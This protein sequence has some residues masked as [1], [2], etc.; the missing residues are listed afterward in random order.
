[1]SKTTVLTKTDL[2]KLEAMLTEACNDEDILENEACR[3]DSLLTSGKCWRALY[4]WPPITGRLLGLL[5]TVTQNPSLVNEI[6][7]NPVYK[8]AR[9][10]FFSAGQVPF[11]N[12][13][14]KLIQKRDPNFDLLKAGLKLMAHHLGLSETAF[15]DIESAGWENFQACVDYAE[16]TLDIETPIVANT[17][18]GD[19]PF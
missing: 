7:G 18:Q 15:E 5:K 10:T 17:E 1:M 19:C 16:S 11:V 8:F 12:K 4:N 2:S 6:T 14:G 9:K 3:L 13:N